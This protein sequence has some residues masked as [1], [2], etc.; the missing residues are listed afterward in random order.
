MTKPF[1]MTATSS[2]FTSNTSPVF[3]TSITGPALALSQ[4]AG[5]KKCRTYCPTLALVEFV[6][7]IQ[8]SPWRSINRSV[9]PTSGTVILSCQQCARL[10]QSTQG[11]LVQA[12]QPLNLVESQKCSR[13]EACTLHWT[14]WPIKGRGEYGA[15]EAWNDRS[16]REFRKNASFEQDTSGTSESL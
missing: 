2:F 10:G 5:R 9:G 13:A 14:A 4:S 11:S 12:L 16:D 1:L 6:E 8:L 7:Q 3:V 15:V